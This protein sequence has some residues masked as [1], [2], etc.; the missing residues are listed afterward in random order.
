[1]AKME[2]EL[3]DEQ[4]EKVQILKENGIEVGEAI[5]M[6]FQMKNA[7]SQSSNLILDRRIQQATE[8]RAE[9]EEKLAKVDRDLSLYGR[10]K[11]SSLDITQKQ[12]LLEKEYGIGSKTYDETVMDAK[13]R[14]K[15]SNFFKF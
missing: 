11:D 6:F 5:E 7:V 2:I 12:K 3:T 14:L 15:W 1:M 10:I 9:L 13:H 8:E 4:A